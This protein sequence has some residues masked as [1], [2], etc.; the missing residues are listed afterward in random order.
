MNNILHSHLIAQHVQDRIE[1]ATTARELRAVKSTR[2]Q[3]P[4]PARLRRRL[5]GRAAAEA[6]APA[7]L[8]P[9]QPR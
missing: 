3:T 2:R 9:L 5:G 8:T 6:V 7:P 4:K 1:E